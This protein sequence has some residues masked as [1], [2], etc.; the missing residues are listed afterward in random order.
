MRGVLLIAFLLGL[1]ACQDAEV[2]GAPPPPPSPVRGEEQQAIG[3]YLQF[4]EVALPTAFNALTDVQRRE[5]LAPVTTDPELSL[6][7]HNLATLTKSPE[8]SY[9]HNAPIRQKAQ[10][11]TGSALVTG[12]LDSTGTGKAS[13]KT[14][15]LLT[16]GVPQNPVRVS[17]T[18]GADGR[19]RV[20]AVVFTGGSSC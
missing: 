19:W 18:K 5:A 2:Y 1:A 14:G 3:Q 15:K 9:G 13:R 11:N 6:L 4:W 20:S 12:C 10:L 8:R 17:L 7:L 16:R